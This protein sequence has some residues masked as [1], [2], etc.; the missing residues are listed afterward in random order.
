MNAR[1]EA[2]TQPATL[3]VGEVI[4]AA[5]AL[6]CPT[7]RC[8][9]VVVGDVGGRGELQAFTFDPGVVDAPKTIPLARSLGTVEQNVAPV[10]SGDHVFMVDQIDAERA[11]VVHAKLKWE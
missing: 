7:R 6:D 5:L 1:G 2:V 9:G 11:R 4:P 10:L 8:R 3:A